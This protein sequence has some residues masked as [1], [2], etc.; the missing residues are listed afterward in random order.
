MIDEPIQYFFGSGK[1]SDLSAGVRKHCETCV[2]NELEPIANAMRAQYDEFDGELKIHLFP[3]AKNQILVRLENVADLF[4]G[5]PKDTP[6][7]NLT[8]YAEELYALANN[9]ASPSHVTFTERTLGNNQ[10]YAE[11]KKTRFR[12][13][14]HPVDGDKASEWPKDNGDSLALQ[15]H[16]IRL[17]RVV[18]NSADQ[19]Q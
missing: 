10:D 11:M 15:P 14:S 17:F 9:G 2:Y 7:F 1:Q 13:T 16:R 4:D 12:W 18:F 5:A 8:Q 3:E 6:Y 19:I